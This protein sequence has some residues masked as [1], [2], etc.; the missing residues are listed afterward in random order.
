MANLGYRSIEVEVLNDTRE[1]L[2]V[3]GYSLSSSCSWIPGGNPRQGEILSQYNTVFWGVSTNDVNGPATGQVQL[4]G[5]GN[6]S[7]TIVFSNN[8]TGQARCTVSPNNAVKGIVAPVL[9]GE[10]N[11]A[12]FRVQ[13]IPV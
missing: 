9:T 13:L 2:V 10:Q 11:H 3:Q 1:N 4:T 6:F 12:Q 5:L 8:A 7:V